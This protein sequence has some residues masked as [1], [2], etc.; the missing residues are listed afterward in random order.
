MRIKLTFVCRN[1]KL[2][3]SLKAFGWRMYFGWAATFEL[4]RSGRNV[5]DCEVRI[6]NVA[7]FR[8]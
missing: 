3:K 5:R 7:A 4:R 8:P 1:G 6:T 2:G